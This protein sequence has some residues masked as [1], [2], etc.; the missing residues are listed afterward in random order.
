LMVWGVGGSSMIVG[1][2]SM[3]EM[4]KS[5]FSMVACRH[6]RDGH[7]LMEVFGRWWAEERLLCPQA[8]T[9]QRGLYENHCHTKGR[10]H[11]EHAK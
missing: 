10:C 2:L 6:A 4:S 8:G 5:M 1:W 7:A 3:V 11:P 9:G